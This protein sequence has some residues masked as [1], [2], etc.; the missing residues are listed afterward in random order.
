[1][2][3]PRLIN[4]TAI[5]VTRKITTITKDRIIPVRFLLFLRSVP[6]DSARKENENDYFFCRNICCSYINCPI[7]PVALHF[8]LVLEYSNFSCVLQ[9]QSILEVYVVVAEV[10]SV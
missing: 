3:L 2:E 5:I 4:P 8:S 7:V 10:A 6:I 1:M 9:F